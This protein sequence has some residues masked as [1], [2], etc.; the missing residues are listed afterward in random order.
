MRGH[1]GSERQF[2]LVFILRAGAGAD[3]DE[4]KEQQEADD[5]C[6]AFACVFILL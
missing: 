1:A 2:E 3:E 4:R 6:E 5:A